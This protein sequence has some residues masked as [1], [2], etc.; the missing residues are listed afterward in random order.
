MNVEEESFGFFL[1]F[2]YYHYSNRLSAQT[3]KFDK[4]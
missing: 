1:L 4:K 3:V 2:Y